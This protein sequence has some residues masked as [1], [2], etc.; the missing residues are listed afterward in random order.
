MCVKTAHAVAALAVTAGTLFG[1]K[2]ASAQDVCTGQINAP[3]QEGS[4]IRGDGILFCSTLLGDIEFPISQLQRKV[5]G[6]WQGYGE[7]EY[8]NCFDDPSS[9]NLLICTPTDGAP[10]ASGEFRLRFSY[11]TQ[12]GGTVT[13]YGP[14]ASFK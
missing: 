8:T 7:P 6:S 11:Y 9:V 5:N 4:A 1:A 10:Y 13:N 12:L 14:S 3:H 2:P